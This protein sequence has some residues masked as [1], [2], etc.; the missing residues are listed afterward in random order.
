MELIN[1]INLVNN[2]L[3]VTT[4]SHTLTIDKLLENKE[5]VYVV[6]TRKD[7]D[8][9][10]T[11]LLISRSERDIKNNYYL[12]LDVSENKEFDKEL[13]SYFKSTFTGNTFSRVLLVSHKQ[14]NQNLNYLFD[15]TF[16]SFLVNEYNLD[17]L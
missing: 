6:K 1:Q 4:L 7:L 3:I 8:G 13:I 17:N 9:S 5:F 15:H 11:K 16:V 12:I 10:K 2:D 14:L